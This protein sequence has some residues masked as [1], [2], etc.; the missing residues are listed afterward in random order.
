MIEEPMSYPHRAKAIFSYEADMKDPAE[1]SF[2][3]NEIMYVSE[4]ITARWWSVR[5]LDGTR[6]I[7]PSNYL[8]LES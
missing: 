2:S 8:A 3:K 7:A 1:I 5:K 6:G 4:D